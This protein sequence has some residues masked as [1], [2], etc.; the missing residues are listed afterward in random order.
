M[1]HQWSSI[2]ASVDATGIEGMPKAVLDEIVSELNASTSDKRNSIH[3]KRKERLRKEAK[4]RAAEKE[5]RELE[6]AQ[7]RQVLDNQR[8]ARREK[9]D[10]WYESLKS[11][12]RERATQRKR[13]I[14]L[15][16]D[17]MDRKAL[18]KMVVIPKVRPVGKGL[19]HESAA[20]SVETMRE[21]VPLGTPPAVRSIKSAGHARRRVVEGSFSNS[22]RLA[23]AVYASKCAA[24]KIRI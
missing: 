14:S 21:T 7:A 9:M 10:A 18:S 12:D 23:A 20:L 4:A 3:Q 16:Q 13:T 19:V 17:E 22:V 5:A 8:K 2:L 1:N 15:V 6:D 24:L 11:R